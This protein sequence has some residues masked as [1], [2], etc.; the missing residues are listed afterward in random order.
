MLKLDIFPSFGIIGVIKFSNNRAPI[1][2]EIVE[3]GL[4]R[5]R[6]EGFVLTADSD[7]FDK[8]IKEGIYDCKL[9]RVE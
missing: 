9:E 2:G 1:I 3:Y 7:Y 8:R 5:F 6:I 4:D